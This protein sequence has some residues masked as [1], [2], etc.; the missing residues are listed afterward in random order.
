[1]KKTLLFALALAG[2]SAFAQSKGDT[3]STMMYNNESDTFQQALFLRSFDMGLIND[4]LYIFVKKDGNVIAVPMDFPA[5][6]FEY[7]EQN[8]ERKQTA[9]METERYKAMPTK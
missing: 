5:P 6:M 9:F 2:A 8:H 1:M 7:P 3:T 4:K